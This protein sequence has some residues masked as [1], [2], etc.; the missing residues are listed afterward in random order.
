M[1]TS[2]LIRKYRRAADITQAQLA[3]VL[4]CSPQK[5]SHMERGYTA[6]NAAEL[7]RIAR[8]L[9][10]QPADLVPVIRLDGAG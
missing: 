1:T 3:A 10:V 4:G 9:G 8:A 6:I 7:P 5:I 2:R